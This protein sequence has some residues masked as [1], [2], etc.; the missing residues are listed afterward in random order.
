MYGVWA[1]VSAT[2]RPLPTVSRKPAG[3]TERFVAQ[4]VKARDQSAVKSY[5]LRHESRP[6]LLCVSLLEALV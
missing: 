3:L 6:V 5:P 2:G 1:T 4:H